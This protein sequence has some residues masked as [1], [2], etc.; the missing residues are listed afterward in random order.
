MRVATLFAIVVLTATS[1]AA[2]LTRDAASSLRLPN[3]EESPRVEIRT[4]RSEPPKFVFE[5]VREMPTPGWRFEIDTVDFDEAN[6][7][8]V[9]KV[10]EVRPDGMAAQVITDT[11]LRIPLGSIA[12]GRWFLEVWSRRT[13]QRGHAPAHAF[14]LIAQ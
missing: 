14:L 7:R 12:R 10:T 5:I 11:R 2:Q 9:A 4:L 13:S 8:I 6:R 3:A 1:A